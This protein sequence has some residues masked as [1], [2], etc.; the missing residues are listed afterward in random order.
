MIKVSSA[1]GEP[2]SMT[3]EYK[4]YSVI[5]V[6]LQGNDNYEGDLKVFKGDENVSDKFED[7]EITGDDLKKILDT[8]DTF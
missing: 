3:I 6:G 4:G 5:L 8:I 1:P 2:F 7:Y